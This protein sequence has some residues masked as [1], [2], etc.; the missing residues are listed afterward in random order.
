M[1]IVFAIDSEWPLRPA[2]A[3]CAK[4]NRSAFI[5]HFGLNLD[6]AA[7]SRYIITLSNL[8]SRA[9][10]MCFCNILIWE[11]IHIISGVRYE[12]IFRGVPLK[13][14]SRTFLWRND[15]LSSDLQTH[16]H[17]VVGRRRLRIVGETVCKGYGTDKG[18]VVARTLSVGSR[19]LLFLA[20]RQRNQALNLEK[21]L[22][23]ISA[24][25]HAL[26]AFSPP[27]M[28]RKYKNDVV[29]GEPNVIIACILSCKSKYKMCPCV[30][31]RQNFENMLL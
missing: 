3:E 27:W 20:K 26:R 4:S 22:K 14:R 15:V 25:K 21:T 2:F 28:K 12:R 9:P 11:R 13:A 18:C 7:L 10:K 31:M 29:L 1:S 5:T 19:I 24:W 8:C 17:A 16:Q 30:G 6:V 23:R